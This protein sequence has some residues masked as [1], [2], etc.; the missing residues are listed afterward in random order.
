MSTLC[1]VVKRSAAKCVSDN[2]SVHNGNA[3]SGTILPAEQ[4]C[5]TPLLKVER[6]VSE[7]FLKRSG[8]GLNNFVGFC[9]GTSYYDYYYYDEFLNRGNQ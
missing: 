5:F 1:R 9:N 2:A 8:P 3:S 7:R 6:P 4:D